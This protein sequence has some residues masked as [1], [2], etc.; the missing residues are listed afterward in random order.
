MTTQ[1][2]PS[3]RP[4]RPIKDVHIVGVN[5]INSPS[6]PVVTSIPDGDS[7][8]LYGGAKL[9]AGVDY[10]I[11]LIPTIITEPVRGWLCLGSE[12]TEW[13]GP[14]I[15][16]GRDYV[17]RVARSNVVSFIRD[18]V[19]DCHVA[20]IR[21]DEQ[22]ATLLAEVADTIAMTDSVSWTFDPA[23]HDIIA[24]TDSVVTA[25]D[26]A[27]SAADALA[28]GD[29]V[30]TE[31]EAARAVADTVVVSDSLALMVHIGLAD[32]MAVV[33]SVALPHG[34][35]LTVADAPIEVSDSVVLA[36]GGLLSLEPDEI[37]MADSATATIS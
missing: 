21:T 2:L 37:A 4:L 11:Q 9:E 6:T 3:G 16:S 25:M 14:V 35:R 20:I 30:T 12:A 29:G 8:L 22:T 36:G 26:L 23:P 7:H 33:D 19:V 27:R 32:T 5:E 13:G 34:G 17:I 24:V 1:G 31:L 10:W 28:V 15:E 18:N